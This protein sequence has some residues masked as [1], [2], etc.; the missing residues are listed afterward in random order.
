M[1][2]G[3]GN[4]DNANAHSP[5]RIGSATLGAVTTGA[6]V[7]STDTVTSYSSQGSV[8]DIFAPGDTIAMSNTGGVIAFQGTSA[9]APYVVGV[10]ANHLERFPT[11]SQANLE[12]HLVGHS[13]RGVLGRTLD[14]PD[15]LLF[16]G[17]HRMRACCTF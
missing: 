9:A 5:G 12:N 17:T 3:N 4:G 2:A 13:S 1:I 16:N 15:R 10:M 7:P 6:T 11:Y 14:S 8:I